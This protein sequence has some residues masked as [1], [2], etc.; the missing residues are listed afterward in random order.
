MNAQDLAR[1]LKLAEGAARLGGDA[2]ASCS[3]GREVRSDL[4]REV[5]IVADVVVERVVIEALHAGSP[6]PILSEEAGGVPGETAGPLRWVVDP[7]DGSVNFARGIPL[8]AISIGLVDG[9]EPVLGVTL[10]PLRGELFAGIV[11][12]GAW[13]DGAPIRTSEVATPRE[14]VLCTGFP[15][16]SDFSSDA[17]ASF[18]QA[19]QTFRKVRLLGSA[20]L[21]LAWVACGRADAYA[22]RDIRLWDVAAGLA[23]VRAAGGA[24]SAEPG[25][26]ALTR[27]VRA[28][29]GRLTWTG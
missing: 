14:A 27:M 22:E 21:S 2:L 26:E 12:E 18:V 11:G 7:L 19:V 20:A 29:N 17:V 13:L 5:K 25:R 1:W 6:F 10:D 8:S 9:D 3:R 23:L 4:G 24:V 15:A 16:A 28:T